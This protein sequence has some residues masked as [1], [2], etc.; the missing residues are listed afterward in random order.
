VSALFGAVGRLYSAW[1]VGRFARVFLGVTEGYREPVDFD[2]EGV[3]DHFDEA[4]DAASFHVPKRTKDESE[5]FTQE[6]DWSAF[7]QTIGA[8]D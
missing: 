5:L 1:G 7:D 6:I 2:V 4:M 3:R 8:M